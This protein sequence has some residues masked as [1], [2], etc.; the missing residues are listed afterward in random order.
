MAERTFRRQFDIRFAT[1]RM[2]AERGSEAGRIEFSKLVAA[3]QGSRDDNEL[4]IAVR[5]A[6][7]KIEN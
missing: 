5:N 7:I 6:G 2:N 3:L 1:A 4:A